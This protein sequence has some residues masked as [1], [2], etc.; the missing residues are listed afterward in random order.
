M[1]VLAVRKVSYDSR[2]VMSVDNA[3]FPKFLVFRVSQHSQI[4]GLGVKCV[5]ILLHPNALQVYVDL[6]K[7]IYCGDQW[8]LQN[9]DRFIHEECYGYAS[10]DES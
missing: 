3:P 2:A 7:V 8:F 6:A 1:P 9:V 5:D 10:C 4:D